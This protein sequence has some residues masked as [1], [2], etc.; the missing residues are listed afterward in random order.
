MPQSE[1]VGQ[2]SA[3]LL[4]KTEGVKNDQHGLPILGMIIP[5]PWRSLPKV[6]VQ[7]FLSSLFISVLSCLSGLNRDFRKSF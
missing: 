5:M 3:P 6:T 1:G 4:P 2:G 7:A